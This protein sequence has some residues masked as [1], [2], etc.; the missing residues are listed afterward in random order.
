MKALSILSCIIFVI[1]ILIIGCGEDGNLPTAEDQQVFMAPKNPKDGNSY[2][3]N[4]ILALNT[5]SWEIVYVPEIAVEK[6]PVLTKLPEPQ[7]SEGF[8][9]VDVIIIV[10]GTAGKI[11]K[12]NMTFFLFYGQLAQLDSEDPYESLI[13]ELSTEILYNRRHFDH[14]GNYCSFEVIEITVKDNLSEDNLFEK[15]KNILSGMMTNIDAFKN[16]Q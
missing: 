7:N 10:N 1:S 3:Q 4:K 9:D 11:E 6:S 16:P 14:I 13:E 8:S 12:K 15:M 5:S 2:G